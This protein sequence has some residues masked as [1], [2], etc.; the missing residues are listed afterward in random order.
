MIRK[1]K[2]IEEGLAMIEELDAELRPQLNADSFS[3]REY[4]QT[5]NKL[6]Q[7]KAIIA[8]MNKIREQKPL[9]ESA[10]EARIKQIYRKN[11]EIIVKISEKQGK[12]L[13]RLKERQKSVKKSKN[14]PY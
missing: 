12:I 14:F 1:I 9:V 8:Q 6:K 13:K 10:S 11:Q 3:P 5:L 2:T 4:E 7:R